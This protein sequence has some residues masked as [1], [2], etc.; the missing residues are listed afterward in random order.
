MTPR[1]TSLLK[2]R[3][4]SSEGKFN[5]LL[6]RTRELKLE[7]LRLQ[8]E[9]A[10]IKSGHINDAMGY[11]LMKQRHDALLSWVTMN[12]PELLKLERAVNRASALGAAGLQPGISVTLRQARR[13][14]PPADPSGTSIQRDPA[15]VVP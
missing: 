6:T 5:Q 3:V 9:V 13:R 1:A 15:P 8:E 4:K 14:K 2:L 10:A 12:K 11:T 7:V